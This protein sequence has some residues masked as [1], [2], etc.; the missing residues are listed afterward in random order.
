MFVAL[1]LLTLVELVDE[2][3]LSLLRGAGNV[4]IRRGNAVSIHKLHRDV[5]VDIE[6]PDS[7]DGGGS[8]AAE[9]TGSGGSQHGLWMYID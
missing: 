7:T 2:N 1:K 8:R 5:L 4:S 6:V 3:V 9:C